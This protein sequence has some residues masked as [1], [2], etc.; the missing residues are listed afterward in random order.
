MAVL[1]RLELI[2]SDLVVSAAVT[3]LLHVSHA[4]PSP[5]NQD[6]PVMPSGAWASRPSTRKCRGRAA[7]RAREGGAAEA[8]IG[9]SH[10]IFGRCGG[11]D[12]AIDGVD[13]AA[14]ATADECHQ[15]RAG[16]SW[17]AAGAVEAGEVRGE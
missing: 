7:C 2:A 3:R 13:T 4:P 12:A 15:E 9:R 14:A 1:A 17:C 16:G 6:Q 11:G 5:P 8:G 10:G